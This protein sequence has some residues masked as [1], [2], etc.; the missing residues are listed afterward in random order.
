MLR[1]AV[2]RAADVDERRVAHAAL[3][4]R[5]TRNVIRTGGP[6]IAPTRRMLPMRR[7]PPS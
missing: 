2:Y 3:A 6:G 4:E 7:W 1:S 5:P